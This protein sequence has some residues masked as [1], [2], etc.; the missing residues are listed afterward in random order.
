MPTSRPASKT[1]RKTMISAAITTGSYGLLFNHQRAAGDLLVVLVEEFVAAGLLR[2]HVDGGVTAAGDYLLRL[3]G[4]AFELHRLGV[5]ILQLDHDWCVGGRGDLNRVDLLV[6]VAQLNFSGA[7][8]TRRNSSD[9]RCDGH[10]GGKHQIRRQTRQG[11]FGSFPA[12][13]NDI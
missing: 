10:G 7:L 13:A 4:L 9:R 1:S 11:H 8:R 3:Q 5:E 6:L 12:V 2:A